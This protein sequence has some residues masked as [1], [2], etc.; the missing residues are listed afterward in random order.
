MATQT[1]TAAGRPVHLWVVGIV[2]LLWNA[3][4]AFD[5]TMTELGNRAYL[6]AMGLDEAAMAYVA[7]F[8]AWEVAAWAIGV[9]GSLVGAILLL[10]RSRFAAPAFLVSLAGAVVGV[11]YQFTSNAPDSFASG[12][13]AVIPVV[14]LAAIVGQWFYARRM[15]ASGVLR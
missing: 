3:F 5:Y 8:P 6:T 15:T 11:G 12:I 2:S 10:A 9:W 13:N 1:E 14:I 7:A 4:G